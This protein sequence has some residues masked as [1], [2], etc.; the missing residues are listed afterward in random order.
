MAWLKAH[1]PAEFMAAVLSRNLTEIKKITFFIDEC[2]HLGL[3]VLGPDI[4]ESELHF[5]VNRKGEIRFGMAAIKGVGE[6]AVSAIIEERNQNGP[7]RS[8]FDFTKRINLRAVNK[9]SMEALA[10]AGAFDGFAGVHRAQYFHRE[11]TD[12]PIFLEKVMRHGALFQEKQQAS[13]HSLFGESMA[14]ELPDPKMPDTPPWSKHQQLKYEREVTG[15]YI[16]GHPLDEYKAE[17]DAFCNVTFQD[18]NGGLSRFINKGVTFAGMINAAEVRTSKMGS[19]YAHFELEDFS[20]TYRLSLFSDEFL[21]FKH[22]L[23]EG[24]YVLIHA[25]IEQ[26][27]KSN[28][29]EVRVRNMVLLGEALDRYCKSVS[30]HLELE[31]LN[32]ELVRDLARHIQAH[33]GDCDLKFR[34]SD[35]EDGYY[36]D[37]FSKKSG[38]SPSGFIHAIDKLEG[39]RYK[40]NGFPAN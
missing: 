28:R 27:K 14:L 12:D 20:D 29:I 26:N 33:P 38:I 39:V 5:V 22:F 9:R 25:R 35:D 19:Q 7:Y 18:L 15:F 17:I 34:V 32:D 36:V 16:S 11:N 4:N 8:I 24:T 3:P 6:S 23:V 31:L 2:K 13:Q 1:Y 30:L 37:L 10:M 21:R 40:L